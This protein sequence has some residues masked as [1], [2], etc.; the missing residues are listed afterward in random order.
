MQDPSILNEDEAEALGANY[1]VDRR[2]GSFSVGIA[3]LYFTAPQSAFI[4]PTNACFTASGL[5]FLPTENQSIS[6]QTMTLQTEGGLYYFD[7]VVRAESPGKAYDISTDD[8][9]VGIEGVPS[10]VKV[11]N[12]NSFEEG[13]DR[14]TVEEY[15]ERAENSLSERSLVTGRGI[16]A[17]LLDTFENIR[18]IA[19]IGHGDPEMERDVVTGAGE[20]VTYAMFQGETV[21]DEDSVYLTG[22]YNDGVP[23]NDDFVS[24]A[25]QAGDIVA[26]YTTDGSDY[27]LEWEVEEVVAADE[28]RMTLPIPGAVP[29]DTILLLKRP[30]HT[31]RISDIPGG[32]LEPD[33]VNGEIEI[34]GDSVHIGGAL[35]IF[36][37]AGFPQERSTTLEAIRTW[38]AL[39]RTRTS[40][41][42]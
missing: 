14:E 16:N 5:R 35:D 36:V 32:I 3:R 7:V 40:L 19:V 28:L 26:Y 13:A 30:S 41:S 22:I 37:R 9:L 20:L 29:T 8:G 24:G 17:K 31:L 23:T 27:I 34:A 38:R 4:T 33:T 18:S 1:F 39:A 6:A 25:V 11:V 15:F 42:M 12:K 21:A 10:V 2:R